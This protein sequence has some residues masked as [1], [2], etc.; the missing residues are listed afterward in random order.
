MYITKE[1]SEGANELKNKGGKKTDKQPKIQTYWKS[2]KHINR[3]KKVS[4]MYYDITITHEYKKT[5]QKLIQLSVYCI[6]IYELFIVRPKWKNVT[7]AF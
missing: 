1:L 5:C 7:A 6:S 4:T 2:N 3:R